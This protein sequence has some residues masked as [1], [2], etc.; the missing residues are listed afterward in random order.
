[1][2]LLLFFERVMVGF[3]VF[4]YVMCKSRHLKL[5]GSWLVICGSFLAVVGEKKE[6]DVEFLIS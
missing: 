6:E 5:M 1:M 2:L 4:N 3:V